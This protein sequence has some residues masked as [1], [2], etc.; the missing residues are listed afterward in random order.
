[1]VVL[2]LCIGLCKNRSRALRIRVHFS[3]NLFSMRPDYHDGKSLLNLEDLR[4]GLVGPYDMGA[5][6]VVIWGSSS[7]VKST[8]FLTVH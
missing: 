7:E 5:R 1:M 4:S 3:Q 6:G 2:R 8:D